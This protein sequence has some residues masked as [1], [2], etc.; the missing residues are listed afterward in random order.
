W[1]KDGNLEFLGRLDHQIKLRGFRI[2]IG[3]IE[4]A[5]LQHQDV[6]QVVVIARGAEDTD[7]RLV[8]YIVPKNQVALNVN[9]LRDHLKEKLPEYMIPVA[10]VLLNELPLTPNGKLDRKALPE[11]AE[12]EREYIPPTTPVQ[13]TVAAIWAEVLKIERPGIRDNFFEMGGHSL[14]ATQLISRVR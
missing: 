10:Y 14:L 6:E 12:I 13:E 1:R 9:Q 8:A 3:E 2:E 11:P 5:L 7:K 4:A